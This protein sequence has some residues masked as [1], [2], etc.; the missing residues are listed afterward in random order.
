MGSSRLA[1]AALVA[2]NLVPLFGVAF[3]GWRLID[4]MLL[5]WLEN[6]VIGAYNVARMATAGR[7][8]V[9][10]LFLVPF[11]AVHYGMFWFV[12]G[13]FV[14]TLFGGSGP[15]GGAGGAGTAGLG[16]G[17]TLPLVGAVPAFGGIEWALLGLTLSHGAS[18]VQNWWLGGA[19][20]DASP[21]DRMRA[22]YGRVVVL[23]LTILGGGFAVQAL[24]EPAAALLLLIGLKVGI[25]LAAHVRAHR[26]E[27]PIP[28]RRW[29]GSAG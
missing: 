9:A 11:F 24:G 18:F 4:V 23:H 6:G 2:A 17:V 13:V 26:P 27:G 5:F 12:H 16:S 10:A 15:L 1:V 28:F 29:G 14:V 20:R 7:R 21:A 8:R 25:D 19:W 3:L 22:P